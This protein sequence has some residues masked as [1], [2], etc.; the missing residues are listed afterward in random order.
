[1]IIYLMIP[2]LQTVLYLCLKTDT[3]ESILVLL[4]H[5]F[6]FTVHGN[7]EFLLSIRRAYYTNQ[8]RHKVNCKYS[9][10]S[11]FE[12]HVYM[13]LFTVFEGIV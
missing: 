13:Q 7:Y 11:V 9:V 4:Y 8:S 12:L 5:K 2:I 3:M 6:H 1:M 10:N